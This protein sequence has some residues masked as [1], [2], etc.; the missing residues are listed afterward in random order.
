MAELDSKINEF[1]K[2]SFANLT[3]L[4]NQVPIKKHVLYDKET[5]AIKYGY[6]FNEDYTIHL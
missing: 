3:A 4:I 6:Y 5:E 2:N 1:N